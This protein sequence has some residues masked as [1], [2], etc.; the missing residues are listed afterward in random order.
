MKTFLIENLR[1]ESHLQ[2]RLALTELDAWASSTR[3]SYFAAGD[4]DRIEG[5]APIWKTKDKETALQ[6]LDLAERIRAKIR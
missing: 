6:I 2:R 5:I 1:S 3:E 4:A